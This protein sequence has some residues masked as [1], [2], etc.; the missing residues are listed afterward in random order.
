MKDRSGEHPFADTGQL[1]ALVLFLIVWAVDSFF[2]KT[3]TFLSSL[4]PLYVRLI[5]LAAALVAGIYLAKSGHG[6]VEG[7]QRPQGVVSTGA[8]R[9][10][11]HPLYLASA[12]F[13]VGLAVSTASLIGL[14][15]A[16]AIFIFYDYIA[17]YEER[18]LEEKFGEKY[19]SYKQKTGKWLPKP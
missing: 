18:L 7:K 4:V 2:L 12:L 10:V 5:I 3:S 8:F 1:I 16:A 11:R 17:A 14:A 9:Y 6:V 13:Y 15:L 19:R